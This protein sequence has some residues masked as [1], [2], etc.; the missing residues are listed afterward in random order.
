MA[1]PSPEQIAELFEVHNSEFAKSERLLRSYGLDVS[2]QWVGEGG[3]RLSDSV[4]RARRQTRDQIDAVLRQAIA[5]GTDALEVAKML[6]QYLDPTLAPIRNVNGRLIR[7]QKPSIATRSPGRGGMGSFAARRLARTE[8]TRAHGAATMWAAE[9]TPFAT[10]V[11][12]VLSG[13]HPR[14]DPCDVHASR[15]SGLGPGVYPTKDVPRYPEHPMCTCH[16]ST[17]TTDD[18]D[19]VVEGLRERYGLGDA[20]AETIGTTERVAP[21]AATLNH[22]AAPR[23]T[24]IAEAEQWIRVNLAD[25]VLI[26]KQ[27]LPALQSLTDGLAETLGP[28]RIRLDVLDM[29]PSKLHRSSLGFHRYIESTQS[30]RIHFQPTATATSVAGRRL[31]E[32][33]QRAFAA[34]RDQ[35][36]ARYEAAIA[37]PKRTN[38]LEYNRRQLA[39]VRATTRWAIYQDAD[40]ALKAVAVHEAAHAVYSQKGLK[41]RWQVSWATFSAEERAAVSDYGSTSATELFAEAF[42]ARSF[43]IPLPPSIDAALEEVLS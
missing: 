37:D 35:Q 42:T 27:S 20:N 26:G 13:R 24:S 32:K 31:I 17:V 7:N 34:R 21:V 30:S 5:D 16:L 8:V 12:W 23:F 41:S 18:V 14:T 10:G 6:E 9:R 28:R 15:D 19:A 4:W 33:A 29:T 11:R 39:H 25:T 43:G 38:I 3:Y 40:D 22:W 36:I 2:R 1:A